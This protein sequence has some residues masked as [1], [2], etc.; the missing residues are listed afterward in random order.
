MAKKVNGYTTFYYDALLS[1]KKYNYLASG[2]GYIKE[3]ESKRVLSIDAN[4]RKLGYFNTSSSY[5][6]ALNSTIS[7][8]TYGKIP[9]YSDSI[10][11]SLIT[12]SEYS[13]IYY[14]YYYD[15]HS[16]YKLASNTYEGSFSA[17]YTDIFYSELDIYDSNNNL[18]YKADITK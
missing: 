11:S 1:G 9:A 6:T 12:D 13:Y 5:I 17:K 15:K 10:Y 18:L 7:N 14:A 8:Y 4:N 2:T 3:T 16:E